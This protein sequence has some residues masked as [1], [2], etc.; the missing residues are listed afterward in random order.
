MG[1]Q[2]FLVWSLCF[3]PYS[4]NSC[5]NWKRQSINASLEYVKPTKVKEPKNG[6][7]KAV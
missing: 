5:K 7:K 6:S 2:G 4:C 1:D 3:R